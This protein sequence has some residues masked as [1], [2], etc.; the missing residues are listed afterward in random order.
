MNR[1]KRPRETTFHRRTEPGAAPGTLVADPQAPKP[2]IHVMAYGP[3]GAEERV[4]I[5]PQELSQLLGKWPVVWVNV[6]GLGDA[7]IVA[8][9]G[10]MFGLHKLALEDVLNTHQR[11]KVEQYPDHLYVVA[12]MIEQLDHRLDTDQLSLFLGRN[13][14]VTFQERAGDCF[15]GLRDHVRTGRGQVRSHGPDYLAYALLDAVIDNYF[16]VLEKYGETL[17]TLEDAVVEKPERKLIVHIH[18]VKRDM[19]VLRRAIWPLR[20]VVQALYRDP[21]VLVSDESRL[22]LRDCYDH[23]IQIVDLLETYREVASGLLDIYL[24]SLSNR[25]NEVMKVLTMMAT[26]FMPLSFVAGVYGMNFNPDKPGNMPE[27]NWP[28]GYAMALGFMA[29]VAGVQLYFFARKGWIGSLT[30][31]PEPTNNKP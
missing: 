5:D 15:D 26:V 24:S 22:H 6:D 27:L 1:R 7:A 23:T 30:P 12:R 10:E 8:A 2:S 17:E 14:V 28:F 18:D 16:P 25:M 11:A 29:L 4:V 21:T 19:L 20:E 3:E 9:I 13:F 31:K